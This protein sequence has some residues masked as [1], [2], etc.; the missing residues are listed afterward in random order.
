MTAP[1]RKARAA[2][3]Q[4]YLELCGTPAHAAA[5][6]ANAV[7]GRT[8]GCRPTDLRTLTTRALHHYALRQRRQLQHAVH[9]SPGSAHDPGQMAVRGQGQGQRALHDAFNDLGDDPS[10]LGLNAGGVGAG[11]GGGSG[12]GVPGG[13]AS[14]SSGISGGEGLSLDDIECALDGFTPTAL[15]NA[16]LH[17]SSVKWSEVGG[18]EGV[19][20]DL[21]DMLELPTKVL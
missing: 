16:K 2:L 5:E 4:S 17:S 14:R 3:F 13:P 7:A 18:L 10:D 8:E 20:K 9:H 19:K 6:A 1:D 15:R 12:G 21:R 11:T